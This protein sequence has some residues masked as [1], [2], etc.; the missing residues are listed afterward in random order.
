MECEAFTIGEEAYKD[1]IRAH[2][3]YKNVD[4]LMRLKAQRRARRQTEEMKVADQKRAAPQASFICAQSLTMAKR[5]TTLILTDKDPEE[6]IGDATS[7]GASG[8]SGVETQETKTA[9]WIRLPLPLQL[10]NTSKS[11]N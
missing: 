9:E 1:R 6:A 7:G 3:E 8:A 10:F 5:M 2:E 4:P 11:S